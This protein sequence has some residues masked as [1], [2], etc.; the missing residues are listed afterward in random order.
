MYKIHIADMGAATGLREMG[1]RPVVVISR[2]NQD[3]KVSVLKITSRMR[4]GS[5]YVRMNNYIISGFCN[6]HEIF[7]I[8]AK[9]VKKMIRDC[10][11][12]EVDAINKTM[13]NSNAVVVKGV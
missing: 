11:K 3:G 1:K 9:H 8:D 2:N 4:S 10:T 7:T 6:A 5:Y 12:S 13:Y